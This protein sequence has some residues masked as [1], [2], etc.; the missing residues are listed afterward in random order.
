[1]LIF[2]YLI[3]LKMPI[4]CCGASRIKLNLKIDHQDKE[5]LEKMEKRGK[6]CLGA[7]FAKKMK[8]AEVG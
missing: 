1:M 2:S 7:R 3:L 5:K 8:K 6:E 4:G